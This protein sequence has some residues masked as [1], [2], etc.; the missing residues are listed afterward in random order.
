MQSTTGRQ[1]SRD[2][3]SPGRSC[4][5][6]TATHH[7]RN[8][9][10]CRIS[11]SV[12]CPCWFRILLVG[13]IFFVHDCRT[14]PNGVRHP[15]G[16]TRLRTL[17][18]H[19]TQIWLDGPITSR[20]QKQDR[21]Y[22]LL[23]ISGRFTPATRSLSPPTHTASATAVLVL[24]SVSGRRRFRPVAATRDGRLPAGVVRRP[25]CVYEREPQGSTLQ[26]VRQHQRLKPVLSSCLRLAASS[27]TKSPSSPTGRHTG[28]P[29]PPHHRAASQCQACSALASPSRYKRTRGNSSLVTYEEPG[30]GWHESTQLQ[31]QWRRRGHGNEA[32]RVCP[33][34]LAADA[35]MSLSRSGSGDALRAHAHGV[36]TNKRDIVGDQR[37][38]LLASLYCTSTILPCTTR[39]QRPLVL[40]PWP[41]NVRTAKAACE[42]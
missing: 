3:Q 29:L 4:P 2:D 26:Y 20:Q 16:E 11:A 9:A 37:P 30:T 5:Y 23:Y 25:R 28:G 7:S 35:P 18:L 15:R 1:Q 19:A 33:P 8:N 36:T 6:R 27:L 32:S 22:N 38:S 10:P 17:Q 40:T 31:A 42:T 24:V 14:L 34:P 39:R 41:G 12:S 21:A 13:A